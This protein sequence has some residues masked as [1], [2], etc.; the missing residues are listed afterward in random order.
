MYWQNPPKTV[1]F[2]VF[3]GVLEGANPDGYMKRYQNGFPI[4]PDFRHQIPDR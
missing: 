3:K 1:G 4:I 2:F